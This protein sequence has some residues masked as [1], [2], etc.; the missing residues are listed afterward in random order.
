MVMTTVAQAFLFNAD[1][2]GVS[3]HYAADFNPPFL[4]AVSA[5]D[6][7]GVTRS[8]VLLGDVLVKSLCE[9]V[10]AVLRKERVSGNTVGY[11]LNL[12][13]TIIW[14]LSDALAGQWHTMDIE[15]LPTNLGKRNVYCI[16]M[17]SLPIEFR[18][19]IDANLRVT[20]GYLGS[21]EIDLGNPIQKKLLM[22]QLIGIAVIADGYVVME[23]S[24]EGTPMTTFP[25]ADQFAPHGERR[26][27]YGDLNQVKPPIP[28]PSHFA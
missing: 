21:V 3:S 9:R 11:D 1:A 4:R 13:R 27:A 7:N 20:N 2:E 14:D 24:W 23:L 26:L 22:D 19:G 10:T 28:E 5:V 12:N 17:A 18:S 6:P 8:T 15:T 16:T 25:G